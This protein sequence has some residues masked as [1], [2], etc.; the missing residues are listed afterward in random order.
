MA[1]AGGFNQYDVDPRIWS[2]VSTGNRA[3]PVRCGVDRRTG[4]ILV[5][6]PHV[7]QSVAV[8]FVTR[9]HERILR[10]WEGS[11]V[12]HLLGRNGTES[13]ITRFYWALATAIDLWEPCYRVRKMHITRLDG[14]KVSTQ[15]INEAVDELKAGRLRLQIMGDY[16]PR[17]HLG[18]KTVETRQGL[19]LLGAG[20]GRWSIMA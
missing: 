19:G 14:G 1:Y 20:E 10:Q 11:L 12:P 8:L 2:D 15:G 3:T 5:G 16:M 17:G 9:Y 7:Q 4:K 13:V 6:W 18:D